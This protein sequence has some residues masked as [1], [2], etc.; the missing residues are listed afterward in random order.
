MIFADE[1]C[2]DNFRDI[3]EALMVQHADDVLPVFNQLFRSKLA[4]IFVFVL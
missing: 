1:F 2:P 4:S 3:R